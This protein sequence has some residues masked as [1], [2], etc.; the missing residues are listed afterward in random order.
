M[1]PTSTRIQAWGVRTGSFVTARDAGHLTW[2]RDQ[3]GDRF[4]GGVVLRADRHAF[5]SGDRIRA[6][7][8]STVWAAP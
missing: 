1:S 6:L 4:I 3:F 5:P 7:P 8:I 2:M